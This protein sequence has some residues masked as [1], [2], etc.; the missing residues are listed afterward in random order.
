M[1]G[2]VLFEPN[3][4]PIRMPGLVPCPTAIIPRFVNCNSD[5]RRPFPGGYSI[6]LLGPAPVDKLSEEQ[7][8]VLGL[9]SATGSITL[10]NAIGEQWPHPERFVDLAPR[11][12][13]ALGRRIPQIHFGWS[14]ADHCLVDDMKSTCREVAAAMASPGAELMRIRDP[15]VHPAIY[16]PAGTVVMGRD[17][18]APCDPWGALRG[19]QNVW[20]ADASVL[21]SGGDGH[22]TLTVLAHAARVSEAVHR[23][24]GKRA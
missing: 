6:E 11:A 5:S 15:F 21:P 10:I 4:V 19:A 8:R 7:R 23:R 13:D 22:P 2:Y 9:D 14:D 17:G 3:Q 16:H 24:L 20:V 1:L 18:R 12:R